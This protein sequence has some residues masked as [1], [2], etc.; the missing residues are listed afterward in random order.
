MT[1]LVTTS[2]NGT[3]FVTRL[4]S[5]AARRVRVTREML[6]RINQIVPDTDLGNTAQAAAD[7]LGRLLADGS[8][9]KRA[10]PPQVKPDRKTNALPKGDR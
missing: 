9:T 3:D 7:L 6:F 8:P 5:D 10:K 1:R 4:G 2:H